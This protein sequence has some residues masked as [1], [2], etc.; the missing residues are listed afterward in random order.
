MEV[1]GGNEVK[2]VVGV[3]GRE[4]EV[5]VE[6]DGRYFDQHSDQARSNE[7]TTSRERP[8]KRSVLDRG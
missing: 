1:V 5:E 3:E 8:E 7:R 6:G 4:K 2:E